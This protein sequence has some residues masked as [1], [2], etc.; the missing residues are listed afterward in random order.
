[1]FTTHIPADFLHDE[2][3]K[4]GSATGIAFPRST[5]EVQKALKYASE[6]GHTVTVQGARTGIAGGAVPDSDVIISLARM[7]QILTPVTCSSEGD[8]TITV[9]SGVLL[10]DLRSFLESKEIQNVQHSTSNIQQKISSS[11]RT[12]PRPAHPSAA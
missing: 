3:R 11:R 6:K 5:I 9:Q 8:Y 12:Q 2:S 1:M 4:T 10:N 7:T